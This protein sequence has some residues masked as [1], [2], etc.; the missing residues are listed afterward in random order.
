MA[1]PDPPTGRGS[2]YAFETRLRRRRRLSIGLAMLISGIVSIVGGIAL[3][4][5]FLVVPILY[6]GGAQESGGR[7]VAPAVVLPFIGIGLVYGGVRTLRRG[8]E[9]ER[10]QFTDL[11][12]I[13]PEWEKRDRS[14]DAGPD[15]GP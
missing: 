11:E 8:E 10:G 7:A 12:G 3:T 1:H 14:G 15:R 2:E 5:I 4:V 13:E 9:A 6:A